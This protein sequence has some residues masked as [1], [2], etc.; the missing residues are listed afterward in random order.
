M[1]RSN[2][3]SSFINTHTHPHIH[4]RIAQIYWSYR[5]LAVPR[6]LYDTRCYCNVRST[7]DM[8]QLNLPHGTNN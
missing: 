5:T 6:T 7:A 3:K 4:R 1:L 8:S 2:S